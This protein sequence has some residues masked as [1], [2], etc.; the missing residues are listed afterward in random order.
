MAALRAVFDTNVVVSA[1]VFGQRLAWLRRAWANGIVV[2][3]ICRETT[4]ELLRVL[5]YPKFRLSAAERRTLLED[6]LPYA[7]V[8]SAPGSAVLPFNIRDRDDA[9][10][11]RL[12]LTAGVPLV[13]GDADLTALCDLAPIPIWSAAELRQRLSE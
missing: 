7:E 4:D 2:P 11:L 9:A 6:F 8:I 5:R 10:F 12:A 13:S 3:V 1:L